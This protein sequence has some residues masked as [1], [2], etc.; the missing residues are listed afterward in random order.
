[1]IEA[2]FFN[3][4]A[5]VKLEVSKTFDAFY[6]SVFNSYKRPRFMFRLN[7]LRIV[8]KRIVDNVY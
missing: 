1:M 6:D 4:R 3:P 7:I 8:R 5:L 2:S